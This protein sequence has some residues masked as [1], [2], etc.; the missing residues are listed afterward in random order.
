MTNSRYYLNRM[1]VLQ[2][3]RMTSPCSCSWSI[4]RSWPCPP[5]HKPIQGLVSSAFI[6]GWRS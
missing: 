3:S 6:P 4:L 2:S 5:P 1:A